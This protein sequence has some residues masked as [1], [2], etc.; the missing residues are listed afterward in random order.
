MLSS[1]ENKYSLSFTGVVKTSQRIDY[2]KVH[3]INFTLVAYDSGVPQLSSSAAV[4]ID[5]V[6]VNDEEPKFPTTEYMVML[7]ENAEPGTVV[8]NATAID[9]DEGTHTP[10][11]M[12]PE[13]TVRG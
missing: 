8:M 11:L 13:I 3:S 9:D 7:V 10:S 1:V 12:G 2:E 5:V 6:N 4:F